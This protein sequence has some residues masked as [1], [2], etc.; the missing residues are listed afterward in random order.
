MSSED[1]LK[2]DLRR[3]WDGQFDRIR[4]ANQDFGQRLHSEILEFALDTEE[5]SVMVSI[6]ERPQ[7]V[8][9]QRVNGTRLDMDDADRIVAITILD[10]SRYVTGHAALIALSNALQ[11]FGRIEVPAGPRSTEVERELRELVPA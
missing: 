10:F 5:D 7:S 11:H 1:E 2:R 9:T 8:Y 3:Q 4:A 6:G